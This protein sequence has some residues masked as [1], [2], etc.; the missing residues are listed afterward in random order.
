MVGLD[1]AGENGPM[2][3]TE[4]FL[5]VCKQ[6]SEPHRNKRKRREDKATKG[7]EQ[8]QTQP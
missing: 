3:K 4:I 6:F 2:A 1:R 7:A 5:K 8:S